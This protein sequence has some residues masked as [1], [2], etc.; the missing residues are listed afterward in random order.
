MV[1][2]HHIKKKKI[3]LG[4]PGGSVVKNLACQFGGHR[5]DPWSGKIPHAAEHVTPFAAHSVV[6]APEPRSCNS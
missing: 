6:C 1:N 4:F 3:S 2:H 5:F